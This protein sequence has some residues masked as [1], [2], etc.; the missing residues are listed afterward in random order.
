MDPIHYSNVLRSW[1]LTLYEDVRPCLNDQRLSADRITPYLD[2]LSPDARDRVSPVGPVLQ[3]W[4]VFM[5]PPDHTRMR[6]LLNPGF[7]SAALAEFR[8]KVETLVEEMIDR[9][10]E[11]GAEGA[12][13]DFIDS[14]AYHLP[15][16]RR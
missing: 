14:F 15:A 11:K 12:E 16:T 5:D 7:T 1:V 3:N 13:I 9:L 10:V 6:K 4:A 2:R 8:P